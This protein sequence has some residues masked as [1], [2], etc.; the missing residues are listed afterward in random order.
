MAKKKE[1]RCTGHCCRSF[2]I[3]RSP[4]EL[5]AEF[6]RPATDPTREKDIDQLHGMLIYL[7]QFHTNPVLETKG[8]TWTRKAMLIACKSEEKYT[9]PPQTMRAGINSPWAPRNEDPRGQH[10]YAC[11]NIQLDGNCGIYETRPD[12][13]RRYPNGQ[14]CV[15]TECTWSKEGQEKHFNKGRSSVHVLDGPVGDLIPASS[16][17]AKQRKKQGE[18]LH[19][20]DQSRTRHPARTAAVDARSGLD[21]VSKEEAREERDRDLAALSVART[22]YVRGQ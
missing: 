16:L 14:V 22:G 12:M 13:C 6:E 1:D 15:F 11:R 20:Q 8:E 3:S 2:S 4:A 19:A 5:R 7:G 10:W 21:P 17:T 9:P 18:R